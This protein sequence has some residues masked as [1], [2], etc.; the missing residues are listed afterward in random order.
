MGLYWSL[1]GPGYEEGRYP[2]VAGWRASLRRS[3]KYMTRLGR[4]SMSGVA[5]WAH[6]EMDGRKALSENMRC[7][8][9]LS[10]QAL[11]FGHGDDCMI[12]TIDMTGTG[13][14]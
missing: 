12:G 14:S 8:T 5:A 6:Q 7:K 13:V 4:D 1:A 9:G 2:E 3:V 11:V 10:T